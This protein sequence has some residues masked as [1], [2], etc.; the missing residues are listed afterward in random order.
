L[1]NIALV[2]SIILFILGMIGTILPLLPGPAL[3]YGGILIYGLM[4]KFESLNLYFFILE[5]LVLLV[6][7]LVDFI[8]SAAS[9]RRFGG[10]KQAA[11]GAV[12]GTIFG[13]IILGPLGIVLGPFLGASAA[14]LLRGIDIKQA[15]RSGFGS[16]VGVIG[17]TIFKLCAE[18]LMIV[19]FFINI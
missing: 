19:Y 13:L 5:A 8:S 12:I 14:E 17:G 16:I 10:S 18:V 1:E 4:T 15:I 7:F 6:T 2:I 3:V 11:V 9:T